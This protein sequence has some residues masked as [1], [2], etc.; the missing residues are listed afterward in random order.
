MHVRF[1]SLRVSMIMEVEI[2]MKN[3]RE[4]ESVNSFE[5]G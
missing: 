1:G 4:I 2:C 3:N 5:F